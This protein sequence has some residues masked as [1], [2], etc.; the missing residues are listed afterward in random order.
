MPQQIPS[1]LDLAVLFEAAL[2]LAIDPNGTGAIN[3]RA[4]SDNA[5]LVSMATQL[6]NRTFAYAA[7]RARA[8]SFADSD[9][10]DL[11]EI[12]ADI[13]GDKRKQ[14]N[15]STTTVYLKRTGTAAT[16]ITKGSGFG[17]P[18]QGTQ[19]ALRFEADADVPAG[20]NV[21]AI[22][23]AVTCSTPGT[24][25]NILQASIS[26]ISDPQDDATWAIY[27]PLPGDPVLASGVIDV[28]AGGTDQENDDQLK[29]RMNQRSLD[30]DRQRATKAAILTGAGKVSGVLFTT[31]VE[32]GD[33]TVV[34]YAGD[35]SYQLSAT[36][37]AQILTELENW[38]AFG[39][40]VFVRAY[41]AQLV[42]I[43][44]RLF[45]A[46]AA[47]NYSR[48]LVAA[49]A[50]TAIV[51]YFTYLPRPDEY[52]TDAIAAAAFKG[53]AEVQHCIIDAPAA[54]QTRPADSTYG[55]VTALKRYYATS[56]SVNVQILDPYHA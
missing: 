49:A 16:L 51:N 41:A 38:R 15:P 12:V 35:P 33:G 46:R 39:I 1:T 21:L 2:R 6:G 17:A 32:P 40:P 48:P 18:A 13:F 30:T 27:Q 50:Q 56:A 22:A 43:N 19:P 25:G 28:V 10:D 29:A 37:A 20:L 47:V 31:A 42:Q 4:G 54:S 34:L 3:L 8:R 24:V 53:H 55:T 52:Y 26:Q 44:V 23:V 11:D 45:M 9:G 14:L 7:D 36:M 5:A